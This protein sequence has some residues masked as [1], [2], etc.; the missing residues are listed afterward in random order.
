MNEQ[1]DLQ[2]RW[3][4]A[5]RHPLVNHAITQAIDDAFRLSF[6]AHLREG[7]PRCSVLVTFDKNG[8]VVIA[9]V[10][11]SVLVEQLHERKAFATDHVEAALRILG[12]D[13]RMVI[14]AF[15]QS[16]EGFIVETY[17]PSEAT[18][19]EVL[20]PSSGAPS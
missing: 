2:T 10:L 5:R 6:A 19:R 4:R 14:H 17:E 12:D 15:V 16:A 3:R 1:R 18:R 13:D 20:F 8:D 9:V 7:A 11:R